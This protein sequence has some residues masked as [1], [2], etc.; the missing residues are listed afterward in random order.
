[1]AD[2][3]ISYSKARRADAAD[4]A[5]DI[6]GRGYTV[7]WDKDLTPGESFNDVIKTELGNARAVIVIW[8][9]TSIQSAWVIS[10]ATRALKRKVLIPVY[11]SDLNIDDIP[12]PFDTIHSEP[13][14]NREAVF[15]ALG[16]LKIASDPQRE[17]PKHEL[18]TRRQAF[19]LAGGVVATLALVK[20]YWPSTKSSSPAG[21][22]LRTIPGTGEAISAVAYTP[23]GRNILSGGWD[24]TIRILDVETGSEIRRLDGHLHVVW[25]L[26]ALPDGQHVISGGD[27]GIVKLWDLTNVNPVKEFKGH[28]NEVWSVV[29]LPGQ[30]RA[31]S[32]SL[33]ATM[34]LWDLSGKDPIRTF[35][36]DSRI[37]CAA[38]TPDGSIAV[39]GANGVIQSWNIKDASRIRAFE[40]HKGDIKAVSILPDGQR[41]LSGGDDAT[42][43]LW[44]LSSGREIRKFDGHSG[45]VLAIAVSPSGRTALS[46]GTDATA[47][48]W[49]ISSGR[50]IRAFE[51]HRGA[52]QA[53]AIA[54]NGLSAITGDSNSTI[55]LW[56]LKET[57]S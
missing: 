21:D 47:R 4:L 44:E 28:R 27:D 50:L 6:E 13:L 19:A 9:P 46:G 55:N 29:M 40:G 1:L 38:T 32:A 52:I 56:D 43:R 34:K 24:R 17:K 10:E 36:Y 49:D 30:N 7:W 3:F 42:I 22:P 25:T 33:D 54:P 18:P 20:A 15:G 37:L 39:S 16:K 51:G 31:L 2:V 5:A 57:G 8:T 53:A 45:N 11:S 14:A 23:N 48:L 26:A 35:E 12:Q 41:M